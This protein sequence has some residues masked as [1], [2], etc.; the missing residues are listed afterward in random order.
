[1]SVWYFLS[2]RG[3]KFHDGD[4]DNSNICQQTSSDCAWILCNFLPLYCLLGSGYQIAFPTWC[5]LYQCELWSYCTSMH[6]ACIDGFMQTITSFITCIWKIWFFAPNNLMCSII[7]VLYKLSCL[8]SCSHP[9]LAFLAALLP[10][11]C[12]PDYIQ[13]PFPCLIMIMSMA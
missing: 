4:L 9:N 7:H 3:Q 8:P 2:A 1:M 5:T 13:V 10:Q 12:Q 11:Q 6:K